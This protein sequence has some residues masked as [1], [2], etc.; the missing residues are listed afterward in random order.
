MAA[1]HNTFIQGINSMVYHA[2]NVA[3]DKVQPFIVF[4]LTVISFT[5][6]TIW[7]KVLLSR[8]GE[9]VGKGALAPSVEQ[10]HTFVPQVVQLKKY[11]EDI[12]A[13]KEAYDG[14]LIVE[15]IHSFSDVMI[16]HLNE[17]REIPALESSRMRAVFTE[18][19]LK[20][21]DSAFMKRALANVDFSTTLPLSVVCGNP[22]TPW[23]PPFPTPLKWATRWWFSRK[24][25]AA[26]EFGPPLDFGWELREW[27]TS[28]LVEEPFTTSLIVTS[29]P[30]V[31]LFWL[32]HFIERIAGEEICIAD[33]TEDRLDTSVPVAGAD[34]I[35]RGSRGNALLGLRPLAVCSPPLVYVVQQV[36]GS[37]GKTCADLEGPRSECKSKYTIRRRLRAWASTACTSALRVMLSSS[38]VVDAPQPS[39]ASSSPSS[40]SSSSALL[41]LTAPPIHVV[42]SKLISCPVV[43]AA[44]ACATSV[45]AKAGS[46]SPRTRR[47]AA[48]SPEASARPVRHASRL[49]TPNDS[50]PSSSLSVQT[51]LAP[52]AATTRSGIIPPAVENKSEWRFAA[53]RV[54]PPPLSALHRL[55][56][57]S[58]C[59]HCERWHPQVPADWRLVACLGC[60]PEIIL[61]AL[62][63]R[64]IESK[65]RSRL[66]QSLAPSTQP[67]STCR[68]QGG[69][70]VNSEGSRR[71]RSRACE[72]EAVFKGISPRRA[73]V[74]PGSCGPPEC[75]LYSTCALPRQVCGGAPP[76]RPATGPPTPAARSIPP[77]T[78]SRNESSGASPLTPVAFR[79]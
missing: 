65:S 29:F 72:R 22:A 68:H 24:I 17:G 5:T 57:R 59:A 51:L 41:A 60:P 38:L 1:A 21:I 36:D 42:P 67:V 25:S 33:E 16:Q 14:P 45:L 23:F 47:A 56:P 40:S 70:G 55:S 34:S 7:R 78:G 73:Q 76:P 64:S 61:V 6:T 15:K 37:T 43:S 50:S 77:G 26:W 74:A 2:P 35:A 48:R 20:D 4:S 3:G 69:E 18:K 31:P 63:V 30:I 71:R 52:S 12:K 66:L 49:H 13:G 75:D 19:E 11:L 9:E 44:N 58:A 62:R 8:A 10:H 54:S 79:T 53:V 32:L 46:G 27:W 28:I 39:L